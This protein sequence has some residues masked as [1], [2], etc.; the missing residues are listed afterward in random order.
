MSRPRNTNFF[1]S[2]DIDSKTSREEGD[3]VPR[4]LPC[5]PFSNTT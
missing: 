1:G 4:L 2:P 3:K 5:L